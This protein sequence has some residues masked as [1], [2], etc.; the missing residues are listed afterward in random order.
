MIDRASPK[1]S[2]P[3]NRGK[4]RIDP[5]RYM[6]DMTI[7]LI[8]SLIFHDSNNMFCQIIQINCQISYSTRNGWQILCNAEPPP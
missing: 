2:R 5:C 4:G 1:K 6:P 8:F 7:T 3:T